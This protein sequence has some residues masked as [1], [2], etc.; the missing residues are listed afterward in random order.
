[1]L[2]RV[3]YLFFAQANR[4][5]VEAL[6]GEALVKAHQLTSLP[7]IYLTFAIGCHL[8]SVAVQDQDQMGN[9]LTR[10]CAGDWQTQRSM[11]VG[12]KLEMQV[13]VLVALAP[14]LV[15]AVASSCYHHSAVIVYWG[16]WSA[17]V[18]DLA[19]KVCSGLE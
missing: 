15:P 13:V 8:P 17:S 11:I 2:L 6:V 14:G 10:G 12:S 16:P 7:L 18:L 4:S 3:K 9:C 19:W 5:A 1:V